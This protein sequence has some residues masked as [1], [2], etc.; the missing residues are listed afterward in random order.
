MNCLVASH[1]EIGMRI[2]ESEAGF[3]SILQ[4]KPASGVQTQ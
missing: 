4:V 1:E 3:T 2:K